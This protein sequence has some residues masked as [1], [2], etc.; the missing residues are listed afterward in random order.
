MATKSWDSGLSGPF[1]IDWYCPGTQKSSGQS[2][3]VQNCLWYAFFHPNMITWLPQGQTTVCVRT[4]NY[5]SNNHLLVPMHIYTHLYHLLFMRGT[6]SLS[7]LT[8]VCSIL[9]VTLLT[10]LLNSVHNTLNAS[11]PLCFCFIC[12]AV[13]L[14]EFVFPLPPIFF[15]P[16]KDLTQRLTSILHV[17]RAG[18]T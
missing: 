16:L 15:L 8:F 1:V 17:P 10:T 2:V 12:S 6:C 9:I 5:Y 11:L 18:A 13:F 14:V 4:G 3:H 7:S